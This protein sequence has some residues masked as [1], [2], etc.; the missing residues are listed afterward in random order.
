MRYRLFFKYEEDAPSAK[1]CLSRE[2]QAE[3]FDTAVSQGNSVCKDTLLN[4]K[5]LRLVMVAE[6]PK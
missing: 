2:I 1:S 5:K 3:D 6:L 4:D